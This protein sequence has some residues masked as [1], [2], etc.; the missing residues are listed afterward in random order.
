[1]S[2]KVKYER[3]EGSEPQELDVLSHDS[4]G[5]QQQNLI[6]SQ[7]RTSTRFWLTVLVVVS[8]VAGLVSGT[9]CFYWGKREGRDF[10][11]QVFES[12]WFSAPGQ[13]E[14]EF[15]YRREFALRPGEE[16][17]MWWRK[18]FPIGRGFVQHPDI[19]PVPHGLA[20]FHQLHCLNALRHGYWAARDGIEP[21]HLAQPGHI[22]HCIDYLRQSI[23][24]H[25]DTNLEPINPDLGGV[26]GYGTIRKCRDIVF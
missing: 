10:E 8:A 26:T 13:I 22:R 24:C 4:V 20:V 15:T 17:D 16:S 9:A 11:R 23:M 3:V 5:S 25:A 6:K 21:G 18:V 2:Y 19:S 7:S 1:M 12:D 14:H